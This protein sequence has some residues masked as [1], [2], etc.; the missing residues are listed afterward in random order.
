M[1]R[2]AQLKTRSQKHDA[3]LSF[4][5]RFPTIRVEDHNEDADH[6]RDIGE[7]EYSGLKESEIDMQKIGYRTIDDPVVNISN[8]SA[9]HEANSD[10]GYVLDIF[11]IEHKVDSGKKY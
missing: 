2:C 7:V 10:Q 5:Q 8:A 4:N 9:K 1:T 11:S 6:N 3:I